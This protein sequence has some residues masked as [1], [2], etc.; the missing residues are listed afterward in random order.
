MTTIDELLDEIRA[1]VD[2]T[3]QRDARERISEIDIL[4]QTLHDDL[5]MMTP[6]FVRL[7]GQV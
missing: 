3:L 1:T 7:G 5:A 2:A 6:R 4:Q